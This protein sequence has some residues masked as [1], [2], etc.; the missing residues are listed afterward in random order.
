MKLLFT[1]NS[2]RPIGRDRFPDGCPHCCG[3]SRLQLLHPQCARLVLA[4]EKKVERE[5][6]SNPLGMAA[7]VGMHNVGL[8]VVCEE[9]AKCQRVKWEW[10]KW[11]VYGEKGELA[12][13]G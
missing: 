13:V 2:C 11:Q 10:E 3:L 12:V 9:L 5:S 8:M 4:V 1:Q 7:V 6:W